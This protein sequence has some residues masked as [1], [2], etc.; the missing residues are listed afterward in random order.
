MQQNNHLPINK[1]QPNLIQ[2]MNNREKIISDYI[3]GYNDFDIEKMIAN[4]DEQVQFENIANGETNMSISGLSAF[5]K[6]AEE[7][8][9]YFSERTQTIRSF[10]HMNDRTEV[11]IDYYAIVAM[12]FPNGLKIGDELKLQGKSVFTF[13][14]DKIIKITDIS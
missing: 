9:S 10:K 8:K 12:D 3:S 11:E 4:L 6:Q 14:D 2:T 5:K 1:K 13:R 7:A